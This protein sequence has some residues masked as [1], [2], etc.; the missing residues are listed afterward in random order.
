MKKLLFLS[1]YFGVLNGFG[2]TFTAQ[3]DP[4]AIGKTCPNFTATLMGFEQSPDRQVS[5]ASLRGQVVI[6]DFWAT[7][8]GPCIPSL[9][10]LDKLQKQFGNAL[11]IIAIS[12]EPKPTIEAF[13]QKRNLTNVRFAW[14][15]T[16]VLNE[17]F[18][19]H[20]IPHTVVIDKNGIVK[21]FTSPDELDEDII[22][23]LIKN[24]PVNIALKPELQQKQPNQYTPVVNKKTP[25]TSVKTEQ[26][27]LS[28]TGFQAGK[29]TSFQKLSPYEY[30]FVNCSL[31]L[32]Y[33]ILFEQKENR[34]VLQADSSKYIDS[35]QLYNFH[36]RI[37]ENSAQSLASAALSYLA[38]KV[39][40]KA[41]PITTNRP[42]WV[43][44]RQ[45][46]T[47]RS[48]NTPSYVA[49]K[50]FVL[51]DLINYIES[52]AHLIN[53][54]PVVNQTNLADSVLIDLDWFQNSSLELKQKLE[55]LGLKAEERVVELPCLLLYEE[56]K[57]RKDG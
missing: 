14:D 35:P 46:S 10:H 9:S 2:Q 43:L 12:D 51:R 41:M 55:T 19:H 22:A 26:T 57:V 29:E 33:Q 17:L 20:F 5:L 56:K 25:S 16:R 21:A 53:Y 24:Q 13:V 18:F 6:L 47:L 27:Q 23:K 30:Q 36:I 32:I 40:L 15:S 49:D 42:S 45:D 28:L 50:G 44:E 39:A 7:Y 37:P 52:N 54:L 34:L 4:P 8:C 11:A 31:V 48:V 38:Q 3:I 1:I